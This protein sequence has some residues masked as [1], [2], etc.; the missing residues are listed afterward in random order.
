MVRSFI[1]KTNIIS[2]IVAAAATIS[3]PL[4]SMA[5][6]DSSEVIELQISD[7]TLNPISI[8]THTVSVDSMN[9]ATQVIQ[10]EVFKNSN[11][12]VLSTDQDSLINQ[13]LNQK[14]LPADRL[15]IVPIDSEGSNSSEKP[16]FGLKLNHVKELLKNTYT[17]VKES[18]ISDKVGFVILTYTTSQECITWIHSSRLTDLEK[19]STVTFTIAMALIFGINKDAWSNTTK[20]IQNMLR[21]FLKKHSLDTKAYSELSIKF[22]ANLSLGSAISVM[23]VPVI[24]MSHIIDTGLQLDYFTIPLL[25]GLVFT[26]SLFTW[27]EH[28][29]AVN[30][31]THP[32]TKF[33]FRRA[34]ELRSVIIATFA[35]TAALINSQ[36]HGVSP[37]ITL[38]IIGVGGSILYIQRDTINHWIENS[39][40]AQSKFSKYSLVNNKIFSCQSLFSTSL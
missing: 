12:V 35:S 18:I 24:S 33:I 21:A 28:L 38:G 20:P 1:H 6:I 26:A 37:W 7:P 10:Q 25:S 30:E 4:L 19:T 32:V 36:S 40:L 22:L 17:N 2:M 11:T 34:S 9:E 39:R 23:R 27:S 15:F 3:C 14:N 8:Q 29:A 13:T 16:P 5:A 31:R